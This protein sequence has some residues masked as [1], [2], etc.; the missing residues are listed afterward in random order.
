M[1][2]VEAFPALGVEPRVEETQSGF[3]V[4]DQVIVQ[5]RDDGSE[6]GATGRG[7]IDTVFSSLGAGVGRQFQPR[8]SKN[9]GS[10]LTKV[11]IPRD[12]VWCTL[13][14]K[15]IRL[16]SA[17]VSRGESVLIAYLAQRP[18]SQGMEPCQQSIRYV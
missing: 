11:T 10:R 4:R 5:E 7:S 16:R 6:C 14:F 1:L 2:T 15:N 17:K 12:E 9:K 18:V 13:M 8:R 3:T